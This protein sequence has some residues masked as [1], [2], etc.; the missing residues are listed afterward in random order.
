MMKNTFLITVDTEG[1]NLWAYHEGKTITTENTKYVPR[2]QELCEKYGFKPVYLTNYEMANDREWVKYSSA[3]AQENKCEIGLHI[4]AWN[5]PPEYKLENRYGGNPYITEYGKEAMAAKV[6]TMMDLLRDRYEMEIITHRSG[7]WATNDTYFDILKQN[8]ICVD[9]SYTP[10]L[11]L[12]TIK[13]Y[14][15]YC[16]NDYRKVEKNA[17]ILSSGILEVPVTTRKIHRIANGSILHK[18]NT[19][20]NGDEM[21]P[22]PIENTD[23]KLKILTDK[24]RKEKNNNYF[25]F[26]IHSSE[27]MPGGSPYFKTPEAV[28]ILFGIL[29]GYFTYVTKLGYVGA[30]LKEYSKEYMPENSVKN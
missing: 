26:M 24:V 2:F 22:R 15:K 8:G 9:C 20:V 1:D 27:L 10:E 14:S 30:T 28:E 29:E 21:W 16:G 17:H 18:L 19:L 23:K 13:G 11:D 3:K 5:T 25:E 4:H 6:E 12:S 7:R